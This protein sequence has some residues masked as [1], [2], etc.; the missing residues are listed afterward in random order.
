MVRFTCSKQTPQ[1]AKNYPRQQMTE[2]KNGLF[3]KEKKKAGLAG[4]LAGDHVAN[5]LRRCSKTAN[6]L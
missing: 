4:D 5:I 2:A 1:A 6:K 3:I